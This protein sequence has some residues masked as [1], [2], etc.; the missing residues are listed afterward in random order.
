[1]MMGKAKLG[2]MGMPK[3]NVYKLLLD[4]DTAI[5][6]DEL[7]RKMHN[8]I[9]NNDTISEDKRFA[10]ARLGIELDKALHDNGQPGCKP[11]AND[12]CVLEENIQRFESRWAKRLAKDVIETFNQGE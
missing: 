4:E 10:I 11:G 6:C 5:V 12:G 7:L 8:E 1:M 3:V 2:R 9:I